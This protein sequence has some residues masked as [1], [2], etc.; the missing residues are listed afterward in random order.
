M[1]PFWGR[2]NRTFLNWKGKSVLVVGSRVISSR[3]Q[4]RV[5][6]DT[7]NTFY[8]VPKDAVSLAAANLLSGIATASVTA[9][10][11]VVRDP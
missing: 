10:G 11:S 4:V 5:L 6:A 7:N 3:W 8:A 1:V 2:V 9:G